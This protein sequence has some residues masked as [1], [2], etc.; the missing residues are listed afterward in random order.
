MSTLPHP[1]QVAR[2]L[3]GRQPG[4]QQL[5]EQL[6]PSTP[7]VQAEAWAGTARYMR[8]RT[9]ATPDH[10]PGRK[11]DMSEAAAAAFRAVLEEVGGV[12]SSP[13]E[14]LLLAGVQGRAS[15]TKCLEIAWKGG[16]VN[17]MEVRVTPLYE[18]EHGSMQHL[19]IGL[20]AEHSTMLTQGL[21][22]AK[23]PSSDVSSEDMELSTRPEEM[24]VSDC[25]AP[26]EPIEGLRNVSGA[27]H[28][29]LHAA[30]AATTA[31]A[32]VFASVLQ[33]SMFKTVLLT[34]PA[35]GASSD[36]G[37][38]SGPEEPY[39]IWHA[40]R[41]LEEMLGLGKGELLG[42]DCTALCAAA[43]VPEPQSHDAQELHRAVA[44][45][46]GSLIETV[47]TTSSGSPLFCLAYVMP[48]HCNG[49]RHGTTAVAF[50]DVHRSLPYMQ[51]QMESRDIADCDLYT[52]V[53]FSLLNCLV[54]DPSS[55]TPT[56]AQ[57]NP[58]VFASAGF[59]AMSGATTDE[60]LGRN[61]RFLQQKY[62]GLRGR[63]GEAPAQSAEQLEAIGHM[64]AALDA[65]Q[66]SL[67]LLTNF[68]VDGSR[69][70]NLLFMTPIAQEGPSDGGVLFWVGVQHPVDEAMVERVSTAAMAASTASVN[71]ANHSR[72]LRSCQQSLQSLQLQELYSEYTSNVHRRSIAIHSSDSSCATCICRLCEH[73]VLAESMSIHTPMCKVV[74]QCR[75]I[76][77][78]ADGTLAR[79]L[80]KLNA[81]TSSAFISG[82]YGS[83]SGQVV[84]LLRTF[85]SALLGVTA[86]S[87]VLTQLSALPAKLE[88]LIEGPSLPPATALCWIDI[89]A[90]GQRKL[91]AL[92]HAVLWT[93]DLVQTIVPRADD[94]PLSHGQAPTLQDFE[95]VRELQRGSH[96]AVYMVRKVQTGDVFAMKVLDTQRAKSYRLATERK[97]L[98]SCNS[99][100]VIRT[101]YAFEDA[102]RLFLVME[103]MHSD[104]K[105]LLQ[106][107]G[108]IP[109]QQAVSLM[110]DLVLALEHMHGCGVYHRDLKPENLLLTAEGRLKLADFGLSHVVATK[111][112]PLKDPLLNN[113]AS[114]PEDDTARDPSIVGTPFY[115]AP[116]VIQGKARGIEVASEWWSCGVIMYEFLTGFPPF[117]GRKVAEIYRAILKLA[118]VVDIRRCNVSAEAADLV[119]RLLVVEP[120]SRLVDA[121]RVKAH[122]FFRGVNWSSH[123]QPVAAGRSP[124][125]P[126]AQSLAAQNVSYSAKDATLA[127]S[128]AS[129]TTAR[130]SDVGAPAGGDVA[131]GSKS[132]DS[133]SSGG[134]LS[135]ASTQD[136]HAQLQLQLGSEKND[137]HLDNLTGL[138]D[139]VGAAESW[140]APRKS[141]ALAVGAQNHGEGPQEE[142]KARTT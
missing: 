114:P 97:I 40:S 132:C 45:R 120:R 46:T 118:F 131:A 25:S 75:S 96:A 73:P 8:N 2:R 14:E 101:F 116:E 80:C 117:Q 9:Q 107:L 82:S 129:A 33:K 1:N 26:S 122:P 84:E 62:M 133:K 138:N 76:V 4:L 74:S 110:A 100:F 88:E 51:K 98:F 77:E 134:I 5:A 24:E 12:S 142:K 112:S 113:A 90:A 91:A 66:E 11:P 42:C 59:S 95:V 141:A 139:M 65:R 92:Q 28:N 119:Q 54:T 36:A 72:L 137:A 64:A 41:G 32:V 69:F 37:A 50:L 140:A 29:L 109:E 15:I 30:D 130:A 44:S 87:Q 58:I 20:F 6:D 19:L 108:V 7:P 121:P 52:F 105:N 78:H 106:K 16:G 85:T 47:L 94:D 99:P 79:V 22:V 81:A 127:A 23:L 39:E 35:A 34:R 17:R 49:A 56:P 111:A 89:K 86:S 55:P 31:W 38:S 102:S 27:A 135:A 125:V 53:K 103:C 63:E 68:R 13:L 21:G 123:A 18:P 104:A 128:E 57:R 115:M 10:N 83:Q 67:T 43:S 93:S 71:S 136:F 70:A 126:T 60:C 124:G 61:C 3:L 48:L